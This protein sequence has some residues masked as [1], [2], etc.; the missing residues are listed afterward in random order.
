VKV[1][2]LLLV[3][4][5]AIP[6]VA[7]R[8]PRELRGYLRGIVRVARTGETAWITRGA[9]AA[10]PTNTASKSGCVGRGGGGC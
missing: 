10:Q 2:L 6:Y 5:A 8:F 9:Q 3:N 4:V 1:R 7:L